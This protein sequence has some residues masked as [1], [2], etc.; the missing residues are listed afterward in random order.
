MN[1]KESTLRL[2]CLIR[3]CIDVA[4]N[5]LRNF[6]CD[7]DAMW[8]KIEKHIIATVINTGKE[9]QECAVIIAE[10]DPNKS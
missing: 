9:M 1:S 7:D 2:L 3:E 6:N 4:E 8:D 10:H 5:T